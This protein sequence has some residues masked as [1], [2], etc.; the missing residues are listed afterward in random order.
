MLDVAVVWLSR[1]LRLHDNPA[2]RAA[3]LAARKVVLA[4][5]WA[6]RE[7]G[8]FQ[9]GFAS[10]WWLHQSLKELGKQVESRGNFICF[11]KGPSAV[12]Q[13][14]GICQ[15]VSASV[16]FFNNVYDPLSLVRDHEVKRRLSAAGIVARS[17]NGELL[18]EPWAVLDEKGL[19]LTTFKSFWHKATNG[20]NFLPAAPT[21][22]EPQV[23]PAVLDVPSLRRLSLDDLQLISNSEACAHDHF[24]D[25]WTPGTKAGL[26]M[27]V[28]FLDNRLPA[29]AHDRA[30]IDRDSTSRLSPYIHFGEVSVRV[31]YHEAMQRREVLAAADPQSQAVDDFVQQLGYREYSR[32]L[33]F[34][35]PFT[36][37]RSLLEHVRAVPWVHCPSRF[38]AWR[39]GFTGYPI[40]DA[41]MRQ[42]WVTGWM[43]NRARVFTASFLVKNLLL[44]WQWGLKHFWDML[45]DADLECDALGWQYVA[46][47]LRDAHPFAYMLSIETES[48]RFDPDG[49]FIRKWVPELAQLPLEQIHKPWEAPQAVLQA[50]GVQLGVN[51]PG[52]IVSE[53]ESR[54]AVDRANGIIQKCIS[55]RSLKPEPYLFPTIPIE[56]KVLE[57]DQE[58]DQAVRKLSRPQLV[59]TSDS[60]SSAAVL[61]MAVMPRTAAP[62][63]GVL[64]RQEVYP[65]TCILPDISQVISQPSSAVRTCSSKASCGSAAAWQLS[66]DAIVAAAAAAVGSSRHPCASGAVSLSDAGAPSC[67]VQKATDFPTCG[68]TRMGGPSGSPAVCGNCAGDLWETNSCTGRAAPGEVHVSGGMSSQQSQSERAL[69]VHS[70]FVAP[71]S[72]NE[73]CGTGRPR[74]QLP[75]QSI[76]RALVQDPVV[77]PPVGESSPRPRKVRVLAQ[78]RGY[79]HTMDCA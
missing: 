36:H 72:Q 71:V 59:S 22:E 48:K 61:Q 15:E 62:A 7:E 60:N 32:Y 3:L 39:Q 47:C 50:A 43:H 25:K 54:A 1:D 55:V 35:F 6:P 69:G 4:F 66:A 5:V 14:L 20:S 26:M 9:P 79:N 74:G 67:N 44:P 68:S 17:F 57:P 10:R 78:A 64:L 33:S 31:I 38:R 37:Q 41:S 29:F 65:P 28:D 77:A 46:G 63:S 21:F 19:P 12:E 2:L 42:L 24:A 70:V 30:K 58:V 56:V 76:A 8:Q 52:P 11:R 16:V 18:F 27:L 40:I 34:H 51:Y 75:C 73:Q 45:L 49:A 53:A 23:V 13:L